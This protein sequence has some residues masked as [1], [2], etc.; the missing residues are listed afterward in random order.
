MGSAALYHLA[1]S[2]LKVLGI[3]QFSIS[4]DQGSHHGET[5]IIRFAYDE[6][7]HYVDMALAAREL[8][9][10]LERQ[11]GEKIYHP[12]GGIYIADPEHG[13]FVDNP[14]KVAQTYKFEHEIIRG[15]QINARFP[16][17]NLPKN[18]H[19]FYEPASGYLLSELG[20]E[21]HVKQ[22][23]EYGA[24]VISNAG[25]RAINP[26]PQTEVIT[27]KHA[28]TADKVI[29]CAGAWS[30]KLM[31]ELSKAITIS[32]NVVCWFKPDSSTEIFNP[33]KMPIFIL[34]DENGA[35]YGF[36]DCTGGGVKIGIHDEFS[37]TE[38]DTVNR[39]VSDED[40]TRIRRYADKYFNLAGA[41]IIDSSVCLYSMTPDKDF[42]IGAHPKH[43]N[44]FIAAGFSGHGYKFS[45]VIGQ[46]LKNLAVGADV[47]FDL[48]PFSPARFMD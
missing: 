42:I 35:A 37:P 30:S 21:T 47:E 40:K 46:I 31:P 23:E 4:H 11:S 26:G 27:D 38:I 10:D 7:M 14:I 8:W 3:E 33:D 39:T 20:V 48:S 44:I 18:F 13:R 19:A 16:A 28:Y 29:V 24:E 12:I 9:Q 36:P 5:R 45:P 41:K 15:D 1:K 17:F 25:V 2:G 32:R 43:D 6:G 22:A 34:S